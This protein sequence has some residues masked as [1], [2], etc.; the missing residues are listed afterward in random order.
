MFHYYPPSNVPIPIGNRS[1]GIFDKRLEAISK[2]PMPVY[3]VYKEEIPDQGY[4]PKVEQ[5]GT[6]EDGIQCPKD[7]ELFT[8]SHTQVFISKDI[9]EDSYT[10]ELIAKAIN[11]GYIFGV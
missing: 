2:L 7:C 1:P 6:V 8:C 3:L 5:L 11:K 9:Y 4:M 10:R